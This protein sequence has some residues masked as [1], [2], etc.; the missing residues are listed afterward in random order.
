MRPVKVNVALYLT[1]PQ[2]SS[3]LMTLLRKAALVPSGM[4]AAGELDAGWLPPAQDGAVTSI[5]DDNA[6]TR[7]LFMT[8]TSKVLIRARARKAAVLTQALSADVCS[9]VAHL[10]VWICEAPPGIRRA[11]QIGSGRKQWMPAV[12]FKQT[13]SEAVEGRGAAQ[14]IGMHPD[15]TSISADAPCRPHPSP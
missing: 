8:G 15:W 1:P 13:Q 12:W 10:R 5:S 9:V 11:P 7:I 2:S 3:E 6:I 14:A 4:P